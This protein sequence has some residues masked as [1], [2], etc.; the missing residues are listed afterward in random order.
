MDVM[1]TPFA[2][3]S[4]TPRQ[5]EIVCLARQGYSTDALIDTLCITPTTL[6]WHLCQIRQVLS[7]F[8]LRDGL[9]DMDGLTTRER[10]VALLIAEGLSNRDI[11]ARLTVSRTT[12]ATHVARLLRKTGTTNRVQLALLTRTTALS[13]VALADR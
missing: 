8:A 10:E 7:D 11:G 2:V 9:H 4:L 13:G 3:H 5:Q 12:V 1:C 6:R